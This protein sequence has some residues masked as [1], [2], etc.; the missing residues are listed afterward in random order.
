MKMFLKTV[1]YHITHKQHTIGTK[2][3]L[4]PSKSER[5]LLFLVNLP[6]PEAVLWIQIRLFFSLMPIHI[7]LRNRLWIRILPC[8]KTNVEK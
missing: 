8:V 5:F 2:A 6:A 7:R 3:M 4:K 1:I